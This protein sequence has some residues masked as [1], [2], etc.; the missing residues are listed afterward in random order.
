MRVAFF[1]PL[2]PLQTAVADHSEGLIPHLAALVDLDLFI[3]DGYTPN[4][5]EISRRFDILSFRDFCA[6]A[7]RYDVVLYAMG[8]NAAF[9]GYVYE[10]LQRFPGVVILH[11]TTLHRMVINLAARRGRLEMYLEAMREAYGLADIRL[12]QQILSGYGEE[13]VR[14]YPLLEQVASSSLGVVVHNEYARRQ[15]LNCCPEARVVRINQHFFLPPGFPHQTDV[16]ALRTR[17]GLEGRFVVGSCGIFVP[18]KRLDVCLRAFARLREQYPEAVYLLVGKYQ[19][20]YDLP[21]LIHRLG[22]DQHCTVTGWMDPVAFTQHM[23][24]LDVA[25][26]LRYPHI[27][28]TPFTPIRLMGLGVP[29]VLSDIEPLAELPE[30]TCAK[31]PVDAFEEETLLEILRLLRERDGL[32]LQLGQNGAH[33]IQ[34]HHDPAKIA[35]QYAAFL[36]EAVT[37]N[38]VRD[39]SS[40]C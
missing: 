16:S 27:G 35:A 40:V 39:A 32:R 2:S 29:T 10:M 36:E 5:P 4:N 33:W 24:L 31:I 38:T 13:Y 8:Q 7:G 12:A 21:G 23:Y 34:E 18:H 6:R 11:D 19:R 30:G 28:G 1:S 22:L 20:D 9:H 25:I 37:A 15:V 26:H 14:R 3:D 17:W